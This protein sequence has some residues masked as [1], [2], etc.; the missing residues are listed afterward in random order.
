VSIKVL[1]VDDS[2]VVRQVLTQQLDGVQGIKVIGSATDPLFAMKKMAVQ[3]PDVIILDIEMPRMD[4]ITFLKKIMAEHPTP[5]VICSTLTDRGAAVTMEAMASGAVDI[6]TKPKIGLK[7]F[8]GCFHPE[9]SR[10]E[11]FLQFV[12]GGGVDGASTKQ[13]ADLA[14]GFVE[15]RCGLFKTFLEFAEKRLHESVAAERNGRSRVSLN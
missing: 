4:G 2:A 5:V 15:G 9:V 11:R 3:W 14:K 7:D 6:I 10:V 12:E 13:S 1:I 8:L